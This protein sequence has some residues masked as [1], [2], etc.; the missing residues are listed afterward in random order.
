MGNVPVPQ[1]LPDP[2][3]PDSASRRAVFIFRWS[4]RKEPAVNTP[5]R[6]V[7]RHVNAVVSGAAA[8]PRISEKCSYC[9]SVDGINKDAQP[10]SEA[11]EKARRGETSVCVEL[12]ACFLAALDD[13]PSLQR[14]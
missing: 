7:L 3:S 5:A 1:N 8:E 13:F 9:I 14:D 10:A 6:Q 4:R 11:S 12:S 2:G